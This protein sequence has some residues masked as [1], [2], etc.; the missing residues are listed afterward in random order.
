MAKSADL[1]LAPLDEPTADQ[2]ADASLKRAEAIRSGVLKA[3]GRPA[4]LYAVAVV[5]LWGNHYRVNVV[6]GDGPTEVRIPDSFFVTADGAGTILGS[7][8]R[9][10]KLY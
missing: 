1:P 2:K 3:L 8:P 10:R 5:P 7:T 4:K 6:T 9:I